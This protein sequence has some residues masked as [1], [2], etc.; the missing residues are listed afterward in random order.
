VK[1]QAKSS[2]KILRPVPPLSPTPRIAKNF[3]EKFFASP[4]LSTAARTSARPTL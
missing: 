3:H 2:A 4:S 1:D